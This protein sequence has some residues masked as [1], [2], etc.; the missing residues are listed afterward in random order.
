[1]CGLGG[2]VTHTLYSIV[3]CEKITGQLCNCNHE[4]SDHSIQFTLSNCLASLI[5]LLLWPIVKTGTLRYSAHMKADG[6][7]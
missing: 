2:G 4:C 1:M 6:D 7:Y 5:L 3:G